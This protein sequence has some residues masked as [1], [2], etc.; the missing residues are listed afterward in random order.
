MSEWTDIHV[1]EATS[2]HFTIT[3]N[4]GLYVVDAQGSDAYVVVWGDYDPSLTLHIEGEES[5]CI[6]GFDDDDW[7][8]SGEMPEWLREQITTDK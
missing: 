1:L 8:A 4:D 6:L 7:G 3:D 5:R 2:E